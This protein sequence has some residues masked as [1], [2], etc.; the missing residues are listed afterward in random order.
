MKTALEPK[1]TPSTPAELPKSSAWKSPAVLLGTTVLAGALLATGL[2]PRLAQQHKLEAAAAG[3]K[4]PIVNV[5]VAAAGAPAAQFSLPSSVEA[6]QSTPIYPRVN[7]YVKRIVADIGAQVK[8]G[9]LLAEIETPELDQQVH[10]ATANLAQ[11]RANLKIAQTTSTRWN[12]LG[13]SRVVAPQEV[14]ERQSALDARKA[15]LTAAEASLERLTR[16]QSFQKI[17]APFDG[18]VTKRNIEVGQLVTGDLNDETRILYRMEQTLTLRAFVN[19]PQSDYRFVSIGQ[20]VELSFKEVP[21][22]TFPGKVVRTSGS[23]DAA[24]RTLR[25][26]IQVAN[27]A[28]ELVPGLF[29]EVKFN[30]QREQPPITIPER[31]LILQTSGPQVATLSTDNKVLLTSVTIS[32]DLGKT[33]ELASGLPAGT[34]FVTNPNDTLRDGTIVAPAAAAAANPGK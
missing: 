18:T 30:I 26:E 11:A 17:T 20:L 33:I 28:G 23:L 16:M 9:D 8:T 6:Q 2:A 3:S 24:T 34:R 14:D 22:R 13:K 7:G 25:T 19:V 4:Y 5:D 12:E 10:V 31:A 32:R 29:A 21:G 15:D 1:E 27:Q